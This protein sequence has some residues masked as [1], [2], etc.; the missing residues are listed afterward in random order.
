MA[1]YFVKQLDLVNKNLKTE[2]ASFHRKFIGER[3]Q[4]NILDLTVR[5]YHGLE[6]I[7]L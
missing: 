4:Q 1:K 6:L 7:L 2:Q 3:Y 5:M